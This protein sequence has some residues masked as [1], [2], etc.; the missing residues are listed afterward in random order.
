[1]WA[2]REITLG[3]RHMARAAAASPGNY[4]F[5]K[6]LLDSMERSVPATN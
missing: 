3:K 2:S 4:L 5:Y 1:M 6:A